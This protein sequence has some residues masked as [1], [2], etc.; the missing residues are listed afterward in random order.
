MRATKLKKVAESRNDLLASSGTLRPPS[1]RRQLSNS[2][3]SSSQHGQPLSM[4]VMAAEPGLDKY[5][6]TDN[7]QQLKQQGSS[8]ST[9][10]TPSPINLNPS[11]NNVFNLTSDKMEHAIPDEHTG[12][13]GSS[14]THSYHSSGSLSPTRNNAHLSIEDGGIAS[15]R[16]DTGSYMITAQSKTV[17]DLG[18]VDDDISIKEPPFWEYLSMEVLVIL[19]IY[20]VNKT[21]QEL[22]ISSIPVI[23][24]QEF[25]WTAE[26]GGY[27][28]AIVGASVL[29][30]ILAMS[31]F[32]QDSEE[33]EMVLQL[34]YTCIIFLFMLLHFTIFGDY[35]ILQYVIGSAMLFA[36]LNTLEGVIMTLLSKLISPELA[37]GTFN[38]GLL[39]TEAGTF[40]RVIGDFCITF[41]GA[42]HNPTILVNTL[43]LP[44]VLM[45]LLTL[46]L[47]HYYYDRLI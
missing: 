43:F 19:L 6:W 10:R 18:T 28:M 24:L 15:S 30:M 14:S 40:G 39:A 46:G 16:R 32:M 3:T 44:L 38:S 21:G 45:M 22:V 12:L 26:G 11:N 8:K 7:Q 25:D 5:D 34:T 41:F 47:I 13:L 23:T 36:C 9:F 4:V 35:T 33:R 17:S 37:K 2:S 27:Y 20:T 31:Y 29:P 1:H 42:S